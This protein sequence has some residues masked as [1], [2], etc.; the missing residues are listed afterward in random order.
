MDEQDG[1]FAHT[2]YQPLP[3]RVRPRSLDEF[4]GQ[5]HLLGKG[6]V[7]RRLIESDHITSMIFWG[8]PGVGKTTLAQIIA[9]QIHHILCCDE[10]DKRYPHR[11]AGGRTAPC[12]RRA[13]HCICG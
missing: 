6:K 2:A 13:H 12:L 11:H 8:P 1:L 7:L 3:E 5:E 10:W 9:A 4:V